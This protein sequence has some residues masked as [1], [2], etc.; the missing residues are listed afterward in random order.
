MFWRLLC[1]EAQLSIALHSVTDICAPLWAQNGVAP[2]PASPSLQMQSR[3]YLFRDW[4]GERSALVEKESL[5]TS[6]T[7]PTCRPIRVADCSR[8]K[9]VGENPRNHRHQF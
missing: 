3:K 1:A 6:S 7:S 5:S 2:D 9:Q 8:Q 4:V